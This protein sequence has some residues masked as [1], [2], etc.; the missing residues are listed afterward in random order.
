MSTE[1]SLNSKHLWKSGEVPMLVM[2]K[3]EMRFSRLN[4]WCY[5]VNVH[6]KVYC[7]QFNRKS[8]ENETVLKIKKLD[9]SSWPLCSRVLVQKIKKTMFVAR[10]CRCSYIQFQPMSGSCE[11]G[12]RLENTKYQIEWFEGQACPCVMD[13][14]DVNEADLGKLSTNLLL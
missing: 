14:L 2:W 4:R 8:A 13:I 5:T 6:G 11:H 12:W 10:R 1:V 3:E 7:K 9:G